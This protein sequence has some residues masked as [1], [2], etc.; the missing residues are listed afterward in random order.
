LLDTN[1]NNFV[2][3]PQYKTSYD[4][5][6]YIGRRRADRFR[7]MAQW[8]TRRFPFFDVRNLHLYREP[9]VK[10]IP[11]AMITGMLLSHWTLIGSPCLNLL[12]YIKIDGKS[13]SK[14]ENKLVSSSSSSSGGLDTKN[15]SPEL[16]RIYENR[17]AIGNRIMIRT[18][19][20]T[21]KSTTTSKDK[22]KKTELASSHFIDA[23]I[24][25]YRYPYSSFA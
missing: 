12:C 22:K 19:G 25:K 6:A 15:M 2:V 1:S 18:S 23:M 9:E 8:R 4:R 11:P 7:V 17:F 20:G 24:I 5:N 21:T 13:D 14:D 3:A 16:A 10:A